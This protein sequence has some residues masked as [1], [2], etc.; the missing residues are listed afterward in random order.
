MKQGPNTKSPHIMGATMN[1]QQKN[2]LHERTA[3][4]P[5]NVCVCVEGCLKTFTRLIYAIDNYFLLTR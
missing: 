1:K 5:A 2:H 3:A 4:E